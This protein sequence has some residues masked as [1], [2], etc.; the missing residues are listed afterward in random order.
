MF[1]EL[2]AL[3][4]LP[5]FS[6]ETDLEAPPPDCVPFNLS[7]KSLMLLVFNLFF[8]ACNNLQLQASEYHINNYY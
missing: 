2:I 6:L 4:K 5:L 8:A 3:A 7:S 1:Q